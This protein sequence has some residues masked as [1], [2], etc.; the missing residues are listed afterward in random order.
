MAITLATGTQVSIAATYGTTFTIS[1][2]TNATSAVATLSAAHG[3]VVGDIIEI[4]S[5]WD[6]LN[7]RLVRVSNVSTNDVTLEGIDTTSTTNYPAGSGTGSGRKVATWTSIT[8]IQSVDTSGGDLKFADITTIVDRTEKQMP[9]VRSAVNLNFTV[10]D[11]P[12][13]TWYSAANTASTNN[14]VIGMRLVFP[15]SSRLLA[16]GYLSLQTTPKI[17]ANAPLTAQLGFSAVAA[18]V[19]YST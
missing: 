5:G 3:V 4:T 18:P 7:G 1:A 6:L 9:T 14:T 8:Q 12:S 10:F 17:S 2:I 19:R 13:Q 15:N 11:D 16:N